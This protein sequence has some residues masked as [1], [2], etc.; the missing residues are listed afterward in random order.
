MKSIGELM[1]ELGFNA[2]APLE[3]QKAFLKHLVQDAEQNSMKRP[4]KIKTE[5][6]EEP[7]QMEFRFSEDQK[8]S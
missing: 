6:K 3:S 8:V 1:L 2:N 4:E 7:L 5:E